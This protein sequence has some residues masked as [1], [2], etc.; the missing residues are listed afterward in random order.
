MKS[1][2]CIGEKSEADKQRGKTPDDEHDNH[3]STSMFN[4]KY[5]MVEPDAAFDRKPVNQC[6]LTPAKRQGS[7]R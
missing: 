3:R 1:A 2:G 5:V 7:V 4:V 6:N